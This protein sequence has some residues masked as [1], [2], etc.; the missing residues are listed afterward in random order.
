LVPATFELR[1]YPGAQGRQDGWYTSG[2]QEIII[3]QLSNPVQSGSLVFERPKEGWAEFFRKNYCTGNGADLTCQALPEPAPTKSNL[4]CDE[5]VYSQFI[6]DLEEKLPY[7][8]EA[9]AETLDKFGNI[10]SFTSANTPPCLLVVGFRTDA[11]WTKIEIEP[12]KPRIVEGVDRWRCTS[13]GTECDDSRPFSIFPT[14]FAST[15]VQ[16]QVVDGLGAPHND[17]GNWVDLEANPDPFGNLHHVS[18][19]GDVLIIVA[20]ALACVAVV[21]IV[22]G[23]ATWSVRACVRARAKEDAPIAIP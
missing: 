18:D 13:N 19:L 23:G 21:A 3:S 7:C 5:V 17:I 9:A 14:K 12:S 15:V 20:S 16:S 4:Q 22:V 11:I 8:K 2:D 6:T 1:T 10:L